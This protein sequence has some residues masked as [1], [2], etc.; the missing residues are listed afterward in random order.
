MRCIT[1]K[2]NNDCIRDILLYIEEL[3]TGSNTTVAFNPL[4]TSLNAYT[5]DVLTYHVNQ[6]SQAEL[7]GN[8]ILAGNDI[9]F[10]GDLTW[11]GHQFLNNIRS[12]SVWTKTKSVATKIGAHSITSITQIATAI[13]TQI[14]KLELGV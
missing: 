2:L 12:D 3:T 5:R 9:L 4:C 8:C 6:L 13:L 11:N 7:I 14:I 10:V 1:I